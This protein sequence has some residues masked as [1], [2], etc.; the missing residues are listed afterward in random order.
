MY[1]FNFH[2][3]VHQLFLNLVDEN[4][5][6]LIKIQ[7][8]RTPRS[9]EATINCKYQGIHRILCKFE[10][11]CRWSFGATVNLYI[12]EGLSV[13]NDG[14]TLYLR[15]QTTLGNAFQKNG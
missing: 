14:C 2:D 9:Q 13:I 3:N 1:Q 7:I 6:G 12:C 8:D 11:G 15:M 10:G 5:I 4:P